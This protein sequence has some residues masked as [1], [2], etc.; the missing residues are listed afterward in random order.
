[1]MTAIAADVLTVVSTLVII[2][3]ILLA[4]IMI[5]VSTTVGTPL[6][7]ART[8]AETMLRNTSST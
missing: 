6:V 1:M 5:F 3:T 2:I 8:T 7:E 4:I